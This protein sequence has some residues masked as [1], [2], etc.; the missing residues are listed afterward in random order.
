MFLPNIPWRYCSAL[1]LISSLSAIS[2]CSNKPPCNNPGS[3]MA[4][5]S[6][7]CL[8]VHENQAL[9]VKLLGGRVALVEDAPRRGENALC[10]AERA[11]WDQAG[12]HVQVQS[13]LAEFEDGQVLFSCLLLSDPLLNSSKAFGVVSIDWVPVGDLE[14][15]NWQNHSKSLVMLNHL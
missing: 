1:L 14:D 2:S 4:S 15:L 9:V 13:K 8:L 3:K 7:S 6:S 11:V 10:A 5:K 12:L